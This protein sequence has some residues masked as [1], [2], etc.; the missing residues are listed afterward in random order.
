MNVMPGIAAAT[1]LWAA[2]A[3]VADLRTRRIP[4]AITGAALCSG[5]VVHAFVA[6]PTGLLDAGSGVLWMAIP[7]LPGWMLGWMGGGDVKLMAGLGAW[8]GGETAVVALIATLI[9]GG[10]IAAGVAL[11]RGTL[12]RSVVGAAQLAIGM[13]MGASGGAVTPVTSEVRFPFALAA[14]AGT[15]AAV[16]LP[17]GVQG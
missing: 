7:L 17:G 14:F 1:L 9:A 2:V 12:G 5:F 11:Q 13:V 15:C 4:N 10:V 8:L 6:G 16:L 3:G